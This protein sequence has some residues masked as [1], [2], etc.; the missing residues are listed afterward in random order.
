MASPEL[1]VVAKALGDPTRLKIFEIILAGRSGSCCSPA[2]DCCPD[3]VCVCDIVAQLGM[4]QSKVS[5]HLRELKEAG[6][7]VETRRGRWNYY[8]AALGQLA[9]FAN[10]IG[11]MAQQPSI[12]QG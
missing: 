6:L 4:I 12:G 9:G 1:S 10:A 7:I 2:D 5:Y 11:A 8:Q 3:A